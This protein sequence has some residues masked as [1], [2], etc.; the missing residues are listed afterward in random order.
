[1]AQITINLPKPLDFSDNIGKNWQLWRQQY[2][3]F[4]I[5]TQLVTKPVDVQVATFMLS[6]GAEATDIFNTFQLSEIERADVAAIKSR[7]QSHFIPIEIH[8]VRKERLSE[9]DETLERTGRDSKLAN[10]KVAV[11]ATTKNNEIAPQK[12]DETVELT[13]LSDD[14]QTFVFAGYFSSMESTDICIED[15]SDTNPNSVTL[16]SGNKTLKLQLKSLEAEFRIHLGEFVENLSFKN[17]RTQNT[18]IFRSYAS[19]LEHCPNLK[20]LSFSFYSFMPYQTSELP[21][22]INKLKYLNE[23]VFDVPSGIT[24]NWPW[25]NNVSKINKIFVIAYDEINVNFIHYFQN[26]SSLTINFPNTTRWR[27][28]N[29]E[30]IFEYNSNCLRHL[31]LINLDK[32]EGY[33][34]VME[35]I[36]DKLPLL[37]SLEL[38]MGIT[39][40]VHLLNLPK[41]KFLN[42]KSCGTFNEKHS[43]HL[44]YN[45]LRTLSWSHANGLSTC[46]ST[47]TRF[48]MPI[49]ESVDFN[50]IGADD[51]D[52]LLKFVK[53]KSTLKSIRLRF[54]EEFCMPSKFL[55]QLIDILSKP[56]MP[57]R[58]FLDLSIYPLRLEKEQVSKITFLVQIFV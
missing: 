51:L 47:M 39:A 57:K 18:E 49:I 19:V 7:F 36:K 14:P 17:R 24:S 48:E 53:S 58:P 56:S 26:L 44:N 27:H 33:K 32:M 4:E 42:I 50:V 20:K 12:S 25:S 8:I 16:T 6:I 55:H 54:Q 35:L 2:E 29:L 40:K 38:E 22:L 21:D 11:A 45:A 9:I 10:N 1:M 13:G 30:K 37:N 41:V 28:N 31:K 46:L 43:E 52:E 23:L 5:A 15:N 34:H 3:W